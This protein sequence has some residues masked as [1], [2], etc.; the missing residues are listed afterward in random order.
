MAALLVCFSSWAQPKSHK[1][2]K[3]VLEPETAEWVKNYV[4]S[5]S[6]ARAH[7]DSSYYAAKDIRYSRLFPAYFL[8]F[9]C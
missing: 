6:A 2:T 7:I 1:H 5:L 4:D 9:S 3:G 8:S